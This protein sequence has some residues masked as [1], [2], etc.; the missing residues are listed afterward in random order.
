LLQKRPAVN[1]KKWYADKE[2]SMTSFTPCG[3]SEGLGHFLRSVYVKIDSCGDKKKMSL[4]IYPLD[5][6]L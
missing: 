1:V 6:I 2:M 4:P 5:I 3:F